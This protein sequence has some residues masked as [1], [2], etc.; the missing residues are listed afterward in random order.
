M[1]DAMFKEHVEK[2][3]TGPAPLNPLL[4]IARAL[5]NSVFYHLYASET[6]TEMKRLLDFPRKRKAPDTSMRTTELDYS[7]HL[8]IALLRAAES[9][10][11]ECQMG[12]FY[13]RRMATHQ[14]GPIIST[15][16]YEGG[17]CSSK[18]FDQ[19]AS[20]KSGLLSSILTHLFRLTS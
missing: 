14:L 6:L 8:S 10:Q 1:L 2:D 16:C 15:A 7:T 12:V 13:L 20:H 9:L 18:V 17:A 19:F 4:S 3:K 5:L 11:Y